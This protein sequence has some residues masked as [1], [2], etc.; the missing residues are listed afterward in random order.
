MV[1]EDS[2][3]GYPLNSCCLNL[4]GCPGPP[5][6]LSLGLQLFFQFVALPPRL[7]RTL[8]AQ[9]SL[10]GFCYRQPESLAH[11]LWLLLT[12]SAAASRTTPTDLHLLFLGICHA[13]HTCCFV[14]L[15]LCRCPSFCQ[16]CPSRLTFLFIAILKNH[17]RHCQRQPSSPPPGRL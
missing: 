14:P 17:L 9:S 5:T 15:N 12:A 7:P 2:F 1:E 6:S 8:S 3:R 11:V 16:G 13:D 10:V 4:Q